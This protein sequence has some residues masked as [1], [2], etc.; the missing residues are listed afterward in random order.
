ML[1]VENIVPGRL[2]FLFHH[3]L[4]LMLDM[5]HPSCDLANGMLFA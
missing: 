1:Q 2:I 5:A 3:L 4:P